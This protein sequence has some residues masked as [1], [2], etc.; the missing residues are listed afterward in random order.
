VPLNLLTQLDEAYLRDPSPDA[1]QAALQDPLRIWHQGNKCSLDFL[2][3]FV[4]RDVAIYNFVARF[5]SGRRSVPRIIKLSHN[6]GADPRFWDSR[7]AFIG[8]EYWDKIPCPPA[9][10]FRD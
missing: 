3:K 5:W 10:Y 4:K 8:Y 6:N 7:W 9:D 1:V 2:E